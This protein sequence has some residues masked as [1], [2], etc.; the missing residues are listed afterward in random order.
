MSKIYAGI[1]AGGSWFRCIIGSGPENI[2]VQKHFPTVSPVETLE[3]VA[4]FLREQMKSLSIASLGLASFGP[5]D[6]NPR[7]EQYGHILQTPKSAWKGLDILGFFQKSL[8][9]EVSLN[10]DVNAASLAEYKWG[11][12]QGLANFIYLT[13]GTGIGGAIMI[14][15]KFPDFELH[16]E[17]GHIRIPHD[18]KEDSYSGCCP[19]HGDCWE[20][21][22][23][24][25][26]L[27]E[28]WETAAE[29]LPEE[30]PAWDL[31]SS[32]LALGISNL[33]LIL[34]P[35]KIIAGGGVMKHGPLF[36]SVR[37]K[38]KLLLNDYLPSD[39]ILT[40]SESYIAGPKLGEQAGPLGALALAAQL[41]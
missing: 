35:Q 12:A 2:L 3:R 13:V 19:F 25:E 39:S 36:K 14:D 33:I 20:G 17:I 29:L 28:R 6:L 31:E 11:G 7:S 16:P 41:G 34:S 24:G 27:K 8:G 18:R 10:T 23:S 30:H 21:L 26:A 1:E 37:R 15:G 40:E 5:L 32:Y 9:L 22:A 4:G 38:V